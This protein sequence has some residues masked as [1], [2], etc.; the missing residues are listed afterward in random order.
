MQYNF[1]HDI[2]AIRR[3]KST[4]KYPPRTIYSHNCK[5]YNTN[6]IKNELRNVNWEHVTNY[7][8]SNICWQYIKDILLKCPDTHSR[9]TKKTIKGKPC[10]WIT[11]EIKKQMND[12]DG[13]LRKAR[14]SKNQ[15]D[16]TKYKIFKNVNNVIKRAKSKY[17]KNLLGENVSKPELFWK[18]IKTVFPTKMKQTCSKSFVINDI[19]RTNETEISNGFCSF[20]HNA[21]K[22]LKANSLRLKHFIWIK[23]KVL[24]IK[25]AN[26]FHFRYVHI[27][28]DLIPACLTK[29]CTTRTCTINDSSRKCNSGNFNNTNDFKIGRISAI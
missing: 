13:L 27:G 14:R 11:E 4:P 16:W 21:V 3:K 28:P 17:H 26:R 19:A 20:F 1:D 6:V 15:N 7:R 25:T 2:I 10:P 22:N 12:H 23:P 8:D 9:L 5:N 24:S 29:D 18:Y